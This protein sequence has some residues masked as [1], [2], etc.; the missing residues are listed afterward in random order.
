MNRDKR[1]PLTETVFYVLLALRL[2]AHGYLVM[3]RVEQLSLGQ[4]RLAAGTLYGAL[5]NLM[6]QGLIMP[7]PGVDPRRQVYQITD[8][9]LAVLERDAQRMQHM[10]AVFATVPGQEDADASV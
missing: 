9:G 10:V 4:V 7:V 8:G 3:S 2:P 1:L 6:K 5:E